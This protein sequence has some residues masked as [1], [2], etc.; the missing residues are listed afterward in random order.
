MDGSWDVC[1]ASP[2]DFPGADDISG[3]LAKE[4]RER[5]WD[6]DHRTHFSSSLIITNILKKNN[7]IFQLF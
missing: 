5:A 1:L 4:E 6:R 7:N 2:A 3:Q